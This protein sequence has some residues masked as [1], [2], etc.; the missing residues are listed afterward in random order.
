MDI[1]ELINRHCLSIDCGECGEFLSVPIG[2]LRVRSD[3]RCPKCD[4][5]VVLGTSRINREIRMVER[6]MAR[7]QSQ[8]AAT[9]AFEVPAGGPDEPRESLPAFGGGS[10][11]SGKKVKLEPIEPD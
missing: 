5:V 1:S 4:A 9:H 11:P 6:S 10:E 8:L 7:L 3:M 2:V